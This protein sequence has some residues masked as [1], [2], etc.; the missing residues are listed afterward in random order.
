M[1]GK[2]GT[3]RRKVKFATVCSP[4]I[5][6]LFYAGSSVYVNSIFIYWLLTFLCKIPL[7]FL[8]F[9]LCSWYNECSASTYS[10]TCAI[11]DALYSLAGYEWEATDS[12]QCSHSVCT[13][14]GTTLYQRPK[15]GYNHKFWLLASGSFSPDSNVRF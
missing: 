6:G 9:I 3:L 5:V 11:L 2:S 12:A 14:Q 7:E 15:V 1:I 10:S 8:N 4:A 13:A